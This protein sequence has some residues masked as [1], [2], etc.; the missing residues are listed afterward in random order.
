MKAK[1]KRINRL[2]ELH[3]LGEQI[4][5]AKYGQKSLIVFKLRNLVPV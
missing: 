4:G 5:K 2:T 3:L 1:T